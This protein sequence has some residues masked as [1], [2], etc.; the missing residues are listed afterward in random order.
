[1]NEALAI[2][3][4][5]AEALEAAH[6]KRIVHRGLKPAN[7]K[8]SPDGRVKVLDFGLAKTRNRRADWSNAATVAGGPSHTGVILRTAAYVR[9]RLHLPVPIACPTWALQSQVGRSPRRGRW[10]VAEHWRSQRV[11]SNARAAPTASSEDESSAQ[12]KPW[13][14]STSGRSR[15]LRRQGTVRFPEPFRSRPDLPISQAEPYPLVR[16]RRSSLAVFTVGT[17]SACR[18]LRG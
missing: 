11:P 9:P 14:C 6:A 1:V 3:H 10:Y 12:E 5:I 18:S 4:Q 8:L 13:W 16:I 2:A 17:I 15:R 7:I